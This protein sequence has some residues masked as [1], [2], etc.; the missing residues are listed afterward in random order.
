MAKIGVYGGTFNP[1]HLVHI[2]AAREFQR[3]LDLDLLLFV[4]VY[5]PPHKKLPPDTPDATR[6]LELLR[7]AMPRRV[8]TMS[9]V[10]YAVDRITWLYRNRELVGGLRFV[11]E[12]SSL[13]FFF[14]RLEPVGDWQQ[15]L[16]R[17]FRQDFGDSL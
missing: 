17:K 11:E 10:K 16:M 4:P 3:V 7:L 15:R 12:P 9:Q 13:R 14:G 1:P 6:R 8:F 2:L 5:L